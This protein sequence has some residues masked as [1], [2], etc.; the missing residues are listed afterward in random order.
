[1]SHFRENVV[2]SSCEN[3]K[4]LVF[5]VGIND[6]TRAIVWREDGKRVLCPIYRL[7]QNMLGRCYDDKAHERLPTYIDCSTTPDW[8]YLSKFER[9]VLTQDWQGKQLDKDILFPNNKLYSPETC[10]FV[11]GKLNT[12]LLERN[13]AR[14]LYPLGV[15]WVKKQSKFRARCSNPFT[16]EKENLG[17]YNNPEDA[18]SAWKKRKHELSLAYAEQQTDPRIAEAL[19][20]RYL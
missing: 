13:S 6:L 1:M 3:K 2:M 20:T 7:W 10:V 9:W 12:F 15:D 18:H 11:E 19:R 4:S 16:V 5:G 17:C 14:G 8:F